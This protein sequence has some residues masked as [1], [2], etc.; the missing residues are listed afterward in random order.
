MKR[1]LS[2]NT[3]S[4][5]NDKTQFDQIFNL[6]NAN[7]FMDL[8]EAHAQ[9]GQLQEAVVPFKKATEFA[10]T[11]VIAFYRLGDAHLK[12]GEFQKAATP[13]KKATEL[14][15]TN[16]M[17]FND[18]GTTYFTL[19]K[20]QEALA[21]YKK[22]IEL[23]PTNAIAFNNWG[24]AHAQLGE[25]QEAIIAFEQA[26][27]L[28]PTYARAFYHLGK[29]HAQLG[30]LQKAV[31][32]H[33]EA[34][35]LA[36]TKAI[37]FYCLGAAHF[38]LGQF[39]ES[40]APFK[41]AI[42]LDPT[43]PLLTIAVITPSHST[44]EVREI[45]TKV[46]I[47]GNKFIID[48]STDKSLVEK[49]K[50]NSADAMVKYTTTTPVGK[51]TFLDKALKLYLKIGTEETLDKVCEIS[52]NNNFSPEKQAEMLY[53]VGNMYSSKGIYVKALVAYQKSIALNPKFLESY[54]QAK[55]ACIALGQN[56]EAELYNK[57]QADGLVEN[58]L[59]DT[60]V[61]D[62]EMDLLGDV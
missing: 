27:K 14:A 12:L 45:I 46:I 52:K 26:I 35:E 48:S 13:L 34:T 59:V 55:A 43:S 62:A 32:A 53:T 58:T 2:D 54:I 15:P 30:Q 57:T 20:F 17:Y 61:L 44:Q 7:H 42:E 25:F 41:T 4:D 16:A 9:L 5:K 50:T 38:K 49:A 31:A 56:E 22:A 60:L 19:G 11:K 21:A 47:P 24:R 18:L 29:V 3:E 1:P 6:T 33:K 10:P 8:G 36:P 51:S 40:L 28:D 23:A 39:Q 37:A